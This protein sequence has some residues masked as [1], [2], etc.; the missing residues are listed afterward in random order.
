MRY[1]KTV[2]QRITDAFQALEEKGYKAEWN[3]A[4]CSSCAGVELADEFEE[5]GVPEEN[6]RYVFTHEQDLDKFNRKGNLLRNRKC[7]IKWAGDK[8][9]IAEALKEQE[10]EVDVP[11]TD[12]ITIQ[13]LGIDRD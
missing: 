6:W 10:L 2:K 13:V 9:E 7:H 3:L 11:D 5:E 8:N 12:E 4:C 1:F